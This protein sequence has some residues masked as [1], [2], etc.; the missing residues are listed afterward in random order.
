MDVGRDVVPERRLRFAHG[1]SSRDGRPDTIAFA[2][3]A[4]VVPA[5]IR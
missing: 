5:P 1:Q 2:R 4:V 3:S